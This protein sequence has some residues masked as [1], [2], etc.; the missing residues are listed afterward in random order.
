M[1]TDYKEKIVF[2]L[3]LIQFFNLKFTKI[4]LK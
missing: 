4:N 3:I 1:N 2:E